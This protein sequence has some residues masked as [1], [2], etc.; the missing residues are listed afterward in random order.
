MFRKIHYIGQKTIRLYENETKDGTSQLLDH[1]YDAKSRY[2]IAKQNNEYVAH[3]L[4]QY[5]EKLSIVSMAKDYGEQLK[6]PFA[7]FIEQFDT[8]NNDDINVLISKSLGF[9]KY[10]YDNVEFVC[11]FD[12][13]HGTLVKMKMEVTETPERI[14]IKMEE[15]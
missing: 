4:N 9:I 2:G 6:W 12:D 14:L 11:M 5:F 1:A 13:L 10:K 8:F 7:F 3:I 15:V